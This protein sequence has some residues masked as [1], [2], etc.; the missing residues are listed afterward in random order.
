MQKH[1]TDL[2]VDGSAIVA[3]HIMNL[4]YVIVA[5]LARMP[6]PCSFT[7]LCQWFMVLL[8][9]PEYDLLPSRNEN[10]IFSLIEAS[11]SQQ[12]SSLAP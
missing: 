8:F 6:L 10:N 7:F 3:E 1:K 4:Y 9:F 11:Y 2:P 12:Q 5:P